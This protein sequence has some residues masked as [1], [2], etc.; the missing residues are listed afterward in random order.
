MWLCL[1]I[2]SLEDDIALKAYGKWILM[3]YVLSSAL[4]IKSTE[5]IVS[6]L[7]LTH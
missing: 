6:L 4:L 1:G 2:S 7:G 3:C 5:K